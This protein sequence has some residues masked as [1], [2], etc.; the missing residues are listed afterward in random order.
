M[1]Q[2]LKNKKE[3]KPNK[4]FP[5]KHTPTKRLHSSMTS[6]KTVSSLWGAFVMLSKMENMF[7][8]TITVQCRNWV[9]CPMTTLQTPRVHYKLGKTP[10]FNRQEIPMRRIKHTVSE[11]SSHPAW[12]WVTGSPALPCSQQELLPLSQWK[13][14]EF[15]EWRRQRLATSSESPANFPTSMTADVEK[16]D[17]LGSKPSLK[18]HI[19]ALWPWSFWFYFPHL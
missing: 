5:D 8:K 19:L 1:R 10:L 17:G 7:L 11:L 13:R 6:L 4:R 9:M 15:G 16:A 14:P 12:R 2:G 18:T 3:G